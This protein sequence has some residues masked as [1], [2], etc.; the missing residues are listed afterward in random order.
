[1]LLPLWRQFR[2]G[3]HERA[4]FLCPESQS[5]S[6]PAALREFGGPIVL[7]G[8]LLI[9]LHRR[10]D[11]QPLRSNIPLHSFRAN[12]K[13][14]QGYVTSFPTGSLSESGASLRAF[15]LPALL[16]FEARFLLPAAAQLMD[17]FKLTHIGQRLDRAVIVCVSFYRILRPGEKNTDLILCARAEL[18]CE[19]RMA[20]AATYP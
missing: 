20:K 14:G 15:V 5:K 9:D 4:A 12:L 6:L 13:T 16:T 1:M 2:L 3:N 7:S 17:F 8:N 10:G 19:R 11:S 18:N